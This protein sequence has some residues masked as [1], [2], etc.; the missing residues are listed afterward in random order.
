MKVLTGLTGMGEREGCLVG[1]RL[2]KGG[3]CGVYRRSGEGL[4]IHRAAVGRY[5]PR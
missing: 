1:D 2:R 5:Q 4:H 3:W